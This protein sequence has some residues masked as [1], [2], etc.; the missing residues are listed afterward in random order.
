VICVLAQIADDRNVGSIKIKSEAKNKRF[1]FIFLYFFFKQQ[2]NKY[3]QTR[4]IVE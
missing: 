3:G 1:K 2:K 4:A